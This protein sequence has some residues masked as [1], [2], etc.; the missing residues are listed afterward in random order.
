MESLAIQ[1]RCIGQLKTLAECPVLVTLHRTLN[2]C[3]GVIHCEELVN[4]DKEKILSELSNQSVTDI[5][6]ITV[7]SDSG[8]KR[9]TNTFVVTF[10]HPSIRKHL[11]I[12][13]V[14]VPLCLLLSI[15]QNHCGVWIARSLGMAA[16]HAKARQPVPG[17][18]CGQ[19]GHTAT[20][21]QNKAKC[22]NYSCTHPASMQQGVPEVGVGKESAGCQGREGHLL[23]WGP[24]DRVNR[25]HSRCQLKKSA[26][27]RCSTFRWRPSAPSYTVHIHSDRSYVAG[28]QENPFIAISTCT[29]SQTDS[30]VRISPQASANQGSSVVSRDPPRP[31]RKKQSTSR[32][33][34]ATSNSRKRQPGSGD[35]PPDNKPKIKRQPKNYSLYNHPSTNRY[36]ALQSDIECDSVYDS[37]D[38][39]PSHFLWPP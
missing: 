19:V 38:C 28:K 1:N 26:Y 9:N 4:R 25:K 32:T 12:G 3:K 27:G 34:S 15:Y 5:N 29:S 21:C 11:K 23:R 7:K 24:Y 35:D 14:H 33:P 10:N 16:G 13:F 17:A 22:T 2:S 31:P 8:D 6:N 20:A 37:E 36:C 30:S 18:T 39:D